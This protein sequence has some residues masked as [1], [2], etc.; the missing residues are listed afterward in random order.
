MVLLVILPLTI[1]ELL[2]LDSVI[3]VRS[4]ALLSTLLELTW[5]LKMVLL[6]MVEFVMLAL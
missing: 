4:R 2:R 6:V 3:F 5:L 1:I